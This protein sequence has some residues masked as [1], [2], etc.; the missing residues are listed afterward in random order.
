[1]VNEEPEHPPHGRPV[2]VGRTAVSGRGSYRILTFRRVRARRL[3]VS[4]TRR[5]TQDGAAFEENVVRGRDRAAG[6]RRD[7]RASRGRWTGRHDA[8]V[9]RTITPWTR[10]T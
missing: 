9:A 8:P 2:R 4:P 1:M 10:A 5:G 6:R 7:H 3:A